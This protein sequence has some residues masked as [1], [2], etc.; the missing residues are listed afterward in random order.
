MTRPSPRPTGHPSPS[1]GRGVE[2]G[3]G[4][5]PEAPAGGP[6]DERGLRFDPD[7]G[8]VF[9]TD[10]HN[11][12]TLYVGSQRVHK[13]A[14]GGQRWTD[15]SRDLALA[16]GAIS[17]IAPSRLEPGV[18]WAGTGDG[19]VHLTRNGGRTWIRATPRGR[20]G[21]AVERIQAS[22][23]APGTATV[24][25]SDPDQQRA[26]LVTSDYGRSWTDVAPATGSSDV[27]ARGTLGGG[28]FDDQGRLIGM[29][30]SADEHG[31]RALRIDV[32]LD[33][34]RS[35]NYP[36]VSIRSESR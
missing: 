32:I 7:A 6:P 13:T 21:N 2:S 33:R 14:D 1:R 24:I 22:P 27:D 18:I 17:A 4:G 36:T 31:V 11:P 19:R 30:V 29:I 10:P 23:S 20:R 28:L 15:I 12:E 35:W 16:S 9:A 5:S 25:L 8:I 3:R 34:L 26:V